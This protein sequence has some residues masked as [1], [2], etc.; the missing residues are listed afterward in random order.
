MKKTFEIENLDCA[1]CA[2]KMQDGIAK[3]EGVTLV[4][5]NFIM[6]KFT[7]EADDERYDDILKKAIKIC[8][9]IEPD[10]RIIVK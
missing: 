3:I 4:S 2:S 1:H 5:V 10:C 7:L 8:K 9:K 6:Q